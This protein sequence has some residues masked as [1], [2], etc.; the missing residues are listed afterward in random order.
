MLRSGF[1]R[2]VVAVQYHGGPFLGF[3]YL[4]EQHENCILPDGTDL[5]G[6]V[7]VEGR[8]RTVFRKVFGGD[9]N[10]ENIQVSSRTD[11]G[12]HAILNT[13]HVDV[14]EGL[15]I[16][17]RSNSIEKAINFHLKH[18]PLTRAPI[19]HHRI[20]Y[21]TQLVQGNEYCR[22]S[23][24]NDLKVLRVFPAPTSMAN[25]NGLDY[26][27]ATVVDWNARFSA[28]ERT[29]MYRILHNQSL[30]AHGVSFEWDRA[31][32]I[33]D[34]KPIDHHAMQQAANVMIGTHDFTAFQ[35][36]RCQ[37]SSPIVS[38]R[39]LTVMC[40]PYQLFGLST[41]GAS[42]IT[43]NVRANS[44]LYHQ[45]RN[46]VACLV[47]VGRGKMTAATVQEMLQS[48]TRN[49]SAGR[50]PPHGLYLVDVKHEGITL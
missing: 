3:P 21:D 27:Q 47:A 7:S 30:A 22:S 20:K 32:C 15:P 31:W 5:R 46:M 45:V 49:G 43:I 37:R 50:A 41:P 14:A 35:A 17:A 18:H 1:R 24:A 4:G 36:S 40:H 33:Y 39:E 13:F 8:L 2:Y 16:L 44:F 10:F 29:Y 23:P 11:R 25:P 19:K 6:Y 38:I 12:V 9:N 26:E 28:L 34:P 48:A 42:I